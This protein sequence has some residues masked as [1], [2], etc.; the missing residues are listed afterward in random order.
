MSD[1]EEQVMV[2]ELQGVARKNAT[3]VLEAVRA[4]LEAL[5][6]GCRDSDGKS[7]VPRPSCHGFLF[8]EPPVYA[9]RPILEWSDGDKMP[10]EEVNLTNVHDTNR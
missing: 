8:K 1:E 10:A 5:R 7:G 2:I 4:T 9:P 6:L 3:K